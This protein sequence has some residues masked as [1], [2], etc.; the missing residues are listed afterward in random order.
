MR[1]ARY[2]R[3]AVAVSSLVLCG[4]AYGDPGT[5]TPALP[6]VRVR[7]LTAQITTLFQQGKHGEALAALDSLRLLITQEQRRG[8]DTGADLP[9][10]LSPPGP[11]APAELKVGDRSLT[12]RCGSALLYVIGADP[13]FGRGRKY[14]YIYVEG[15]TIE[16]EGEPLIQNKY[17]KI[18]GQTEAVR[19]SSSDPRVMTVDEKGSLEV[20]GPGEAIVTV[21]VGSAVVQLPYKVIALPLTAGMSEDQIIQKFG[22]PDEREKASH[23][24]LCDEAWRYH[25]FPGAV[26]C[27]GPLGLKLIGP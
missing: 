2:W 12:V 3:L 22:L 24:G 6:A 11:R 18:A 15:V 27:F 21:A 8:K 10:P 16:D 17:V 23:E 26:L 13:R 5:A 19:F 20:K 25:C 14:D 7:E 9:A 1:T 4:G